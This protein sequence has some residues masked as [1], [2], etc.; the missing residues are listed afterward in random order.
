MTRKNVSDK[1]QQNPKTTI[2]CRQSENNQHES[3]SLL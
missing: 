1:N 3:S 2:A